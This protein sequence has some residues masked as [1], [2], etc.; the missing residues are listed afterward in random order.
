MAELVRIPDAKVALSTA[1]VYPEPTATAFET[2]ARL[3]YDG[4]EVMVWTDPVSQDIE[5]LRRLSDHHGVP[6]LAVH[7]P[8]LLITQRVWAKDP[9]EKLQRARSAAERLGAST[10]VV[11]PP[12][13]WQRSYAQDFVDGIWRM[14]DETD[15][16][17]AVENMYPWRYRDR[18]MLAYAPDWDVTNQDYRHFTLDLS[19]TSTARNDALEMAARM[20]DRLTHVHLA[21]GTGSGKDE[22]L[23]PGR[24]KQPC[25]ELLERLA[26]S[27]FAGHVVVEVNTRRAMSAAERDADLAEALAF[28]RLNLAT[29]APRGAR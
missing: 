8:C 27:G 1:S 14:A 26:A 6:V 10:V 11:H 22:H 7:A 21:D 24:G 25:A 3:G 9:W 19:H 13:R 28:T 4:V 12:F 20:G 16:R 18:E 2:A 29:A 17:F 5:A 23:V 15:V